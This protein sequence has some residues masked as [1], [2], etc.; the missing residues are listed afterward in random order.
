[1]TEDKTLVTPVN[2]SSN[3]Q[4]LAQKSMF[5]D[6]YIEKRVGV[7]GMGEVFAVYD[8]SLERYSALKTIHPR[9]AGDPALLEQL[10]W[11]ARCAAKL[12]HTNIVQI[13]RY[14]VE[15]EK[16]FFVMEYV[17]GP[18]IKDLM[19][20]TQSGDES[21]PIDFCVRSAQ[22]ALNG[23]GEAEKA[24]LV[25]RD[26][27]PS[28]LMVGANYDLKIAD[29]GIAQPW[30][31][32]GIAMQSSTG[33]GTPNYMAPEQV[34]SQEL[35]TRTD[36]YC[37]GATLY[38]MLTGKP[39]YSGKDIQE[40]TQ[41]IISPNETPIPMRDLRRA[42]PKKLAKI[43][44]QMVA[45]NPAERPQKTQEALD[46]LSNLRGLQ[47]DNLDY[48]NWSDCVIPLFGPEP[49]E[50]L[51]RVMA[52][53]YSSPKPRDL[54][55]LIMDDDERI[56]RSVEP[57]VNE[58]VRTANLVY[59][60][61]FG[62]VNYIW[63]NGFEDPNVPGLNMDVFDA[64]DNG[65]IDL[66]VLDLEFGPPDGLDF[67]TKANQRRIETAESKGKSS[68]EYK[69]TPICV[70]T[71]HEDGTFQ[72]DPFAPVRDITSKFYRSGNTIN[73]NGYHPVV[74][75]QKDRMKQGA[76]LNPNMG[77]DLVLWVLSLLEKGD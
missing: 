48:T 34:I 58:V 74:L 70:Y 1:M 26:I 13:Y 17:R 16:H 42:I 59:G 69:G 35:D 5:G 65:Y 10:Q 9:F 27:K 23:L 52:E 36:M 8:P 44:E 63:M 75:V 33:A 11:E 6:F 19:N 62:D 29:F 15:N 53:H 45:K 67:I 21:L 4:T 37:L 14:G 25:H 3:H 71:S 39:L 30:G 50:E 46:S 57:R 7:G 2:H 49:P 41:R 32:A 72:S 18:T 20:T 43:V 73:I 12:N 38:H 22:E 40:I 54:T 77:D 31:P 76:E 47:I 66:V 24:G 56:A 68:Q 61:K 60:D 55:I 51:E 64:L 28:N